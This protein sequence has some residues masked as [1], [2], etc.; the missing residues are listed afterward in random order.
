M[1]K[2]SSE[3]P[4][5]LGKVGSPVGLKGEVRIT[6]YQQDSTNLK[7]GKVL[8]LKHGDKHTE[9]SHVERSPS[10]NRSC[11]K[12]EGD[13][14]RKLG[15]CDALQ[16]PLSAQR[17]A[18]SIGDCSLYEFKVE[19]VRYQKDRPVVKLEGVNDRSAAEE[20]RGMKVYIRPEDLEP[21][22]EGEHYVRNLIGC[23]VIDIAGGSAQA[24]CSSPQELLPAR[25]PTD[26]FAARE[27]EKR[28]AGAEGCTIGV[29]RDVIQNTAQSIL[30]VET[31]EGKT[32]FIPAVD[33]FMRGID[34]EQG[35]IKVELIPGFID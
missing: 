22:P 2:T 34:E 3:N 4:V 6:L 33:E 18:R 12:E 13:D 25:G 27:S 9:E 10:P 16:K 26:N 32:V 19:R 35:V 7:E 29:L 17:P 14:L 8:L 5:L 21:L 30:E 24:G 23:R 15:C 11:L 31:P 28:E 1:K 20:L